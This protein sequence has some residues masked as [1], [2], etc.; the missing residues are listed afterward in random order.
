MRLIKRLRSMSKKRLAR[1]TAALV[2]L[3]LVGA[4]APEERRLPRDARVNVIVNGDVV[5][6]QVVAGLPNL[7]VI[8]PNSRLRLRLRQEF[9]D[10]TAY[11]RIFGRRTLSGRV[12]DV[13]LLVD[14]QL[15]RSEVYWFS[16]PLIEGAEA[17][18]GPLMFVQ[19]RVTF[20]LEGAEAGP[21]SRYRFKLL[22]GPRTVAG[23]MLDDHG[24]PFLTLFNLEQPRDYPLASAALGAHLARHYGG[25]LSGP[26]WDSEIVFGIKRPV[27]WLT[28]ARPVRF[29]PIILSK[30]AVRVRD[31]V[32]GSGTGAGRIREA[33]EPVDLEEVTVE[34]G[35][36]G[37]RPIYSLSLPR[38]LLAPCAR[39]TF[40]KRA[41]QIELVCPAG[42]RLAAG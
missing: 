29:G 18:L 27:R 23:T 39:L 6:A 14:D 25:T 26:S 5:R 4:A 40:D 30:L 12:R 17:T 33:D 10:D 11:L 2:P 7:L 16:R 34:A 13:S 32:D 21:L 9:D 42:T 31:R 41:R 20:P 1:A 28:L 37:P 24:Q 19:P 15:R 8:A 38:A 36:R 3:V 35:R 22:G